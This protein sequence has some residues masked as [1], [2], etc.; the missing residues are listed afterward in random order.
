MSIFHVILNKY[1]GTSKNKK[2]NVTKK[3]S[4]L[5]KVVKIVNS[6]HFQCISNNIIEFNYII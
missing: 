6:I 1:K 2:I 3:I 4:K 5:K